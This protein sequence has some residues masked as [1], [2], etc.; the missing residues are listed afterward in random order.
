M[1]PADVAL[2]RHS[3]RA[4]WMRGVERMHRPAQPVDR[5]RGGDV[6]GARE[7]LG[8]GDRQRRDRGRRLRAVDERQPFLRRRAST[9]DKPG[10]A[11]A[12]RAPAQQR[13]VVADRGVPLADE[14]ERQVRERRE[15]AARADRPAARHQRVDAA[16]EQRRSAAR[17]SS[18]GC[19]RSPWPARSRAAPSIA[20]TA[21][22]G[23]GSP[24]PA[25][26]LRS[27]FTLQ[28]AERVAR[29]RRLGERAEPGVDAVDRRVAGGLP[30]DDRARRVD[31]R[32]RPRARAP[33]GSSSSAMASNSS[34]VRREP[35]RRI[36][37]TLNVQP[38][39]G[40]LPGEAAR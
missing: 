23:S 2:A 27:R 38:V 21:R 9:G 40:Q 22:T 13:R 20:R 33:T 14:H 4:A 5:Q 35:S 39:R 17:A 11:R 3:G 36:I 29:N 32:R 10:G 28:R 19:P 30:I 31:A 18:G 15:V 6:G 26:W 7:P 16:V 34:S 37:D 24:T 1:L 12:R 8:A 25:A